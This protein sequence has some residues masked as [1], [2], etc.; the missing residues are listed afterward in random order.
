MDTLSR[1]KQIQII[2]ALTAGMSIRAVER[3]IGIHR[4]TIMR[5]GARVGRGCTE[6]HDC[7]FVGL[8]V[9]RLELDELWAYVGCKQKNV[10]REDLAIPV[11]V[12]HE[13]KTA[14]RDDD[15]LLGGCA[16][17]EGTGNVEEQVIAGTRFRRVIP[18]GIHLIIK[19][20]QW[21]R[22]SVTNKNTLCP[23]WVPLQTSAR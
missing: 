1:D 2:A 8:R 11:D 6:L 21:L 9:G 7:L 16:A 22:R 19:M 15:V 3:L 13:C 20:G 4:D 14:S 18:E 23:R 17:H 10:A 12:W 5:L